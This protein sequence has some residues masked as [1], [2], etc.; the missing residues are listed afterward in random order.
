MSTGSSAEAEAAARQ[1]ALEAEQRRQAEVARE[2][3]AQQ[4]RHREEEEQQHQRAQAQERAQ[5]QAH[6]RE[7]QTRPHQP[8]DSHGLGA[9]LGGLSAAAQE[10]LS[11]GGGSSSRPNKPGDASHPNSANTGGHAQAE[12]HGPV[13]KGADAAF[14]KLESQDKG[15]QQKLANDA[16]KLLENHVNDR[17]TSKYDEQIVADASKVGVLAKTIDPTVN[18][19]Y[20]G[21]T[22]TISGQAMRATAA[23][24]QD[25]LIKGPDVLKAAKQDGQNTVMQQ[26]ANAVTQQAVT[27]VNHAQSVLDGSLN[28]KKQLDQR[29]GAELAQVSPG[30]TKAQQQKFIDSFKAEH[31]YSELDHQINEAASSLDTALKDNKPTLDESLTDGGANLAPVRGGDPT[32][33]A[34]KVSSTDVAD[35]S[36]NAIK[37][38]AST[39]KAGDA[40]KISSSL[41]ADKSLRGALD[42]ADDGGLKDTMN[43]VLENAVPRVGMQMLSKANKDN[44]ANAGKGGKEAE[45]KE[46]ND[47]ITQLKEQLEPFDKAN[48]MVGA[49]NKLAKSLPALKDALNGNFE[50]MKALV[51]TWAKEDPSAL[52]K[53]S[54]SMEKGFAAL[55]TAFGADNFA[56]AGGLKDLANGLGSTAAGLDVFAN[57]ADSLGRFAPGLGVIANLT[58]A[59]FDASKGTV[60]GFTAAAG[61]VIS[62][63]GS[64]LEANPGTAPI[65]ALADA[66]GTIVSGLGYGID[67]LFGGGP[68]SPNDEAAHILNKD[69]HLG[70]KFSDTL[71]HASLS[72][73]HALQQHGANTQE[74]DTLLK[75]TYG[76]NTPSLDDL[77][78]MHDSG[79]SNAQ[80]EQLIG[81]TNGPSHANLDVVAGLSNIGVSPKEIEAL[82]QDK[83]F[84]DVVTKDAGR[85]ALAV[86]Y[87]YDVSGDQN[88]GQML[89]GLAYQFSR[90]N[91]DPYNRGIY[92]GLASGIGAGWKHFEGSE[93]RA[94][95]NASIGAHARGENPQD[96]EQ[97]AKDLELGLPQLPFYYPGKT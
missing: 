5:Q 33:G 17:A 55:A 25:G 76:P 59:G 48:L 79:A 80:L 58:A 61:D 1:A 32:V 66:A 16:E 67:A 39:N 45:D 82:S 6:E 92:P 11:W 37:D 41:L 89:Q 43:S 30:L 23:A 40:L 84:S 35:A 7:A 29:L 83:N 64:G 14:Q 57:S 42:H 46:H 73:L 18:N 36:L 27:N 91:E 13:D 26:A 3:A 31:K 47:L 69:M 63:I 97:M 24:V 90:E 68:Q 22:G 44:L 9:A 28:Q 77:T 81:L 70:G 12:P 95:N 52:M 85:D 50:P 2:R 65:G 94:F 86:A 72:D 4:A 20:V 71:A 88:F 75:R 60:G 62:A 10:A 93:S 51:A 56:N 54:E 21:A 87:K 53:G 38:L 34:D 96:P 74:V 49:T 8:V 19:Q 15:D 78:K